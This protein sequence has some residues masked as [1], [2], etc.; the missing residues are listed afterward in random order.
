MRCRENIINIIIV[1]TGAISCLLSVLFINNFI[2]STIF[3]YIFIFTFL[4]IS[5]CYVSSKIFS[6]ITLILFL[7]IYGSKAYS[8]IFYLLYLLIVYLSILFNKKFLSKIKF[9]DKKI[10]YVIFSMLIFKLFDLFYTILVNSYANLYSVL[11]VSGIISADIFYLLLIFLVVIFLVSLFNNFHR[12]NCFLVIVLFIILIANVFKVM[13][14]G[15]PLTINDMI[16]SFTGSK[17]G[18]FLDS[19][20]ISFF[21]EKIV[22]FGMIVVIVGLILNISYKKFNKKFFESKK[23]RFVILMIAFFCLMVLVIPNKFFYNVILNGVFKTNVNKEYDAIVFVK[24]SYEKFGLTLGTYKNYI[25]SLRFEPDDYDVLEVEN[26]LNKKYQLGDKSLKKPN[27][28]MVFSESFW[29]VTKVDGIKFDKDV[30]PNFNS[31]KNKGKV[32]DL[33]TPTL[34]GYSANVEFEVLTGNS[35]NYLSLGTIPYINIYSTKNGYKYPSVI[36]ELKNNGYKTN[37]ISAAS[38]SLFSTESVYKNMGVDH[39]RFLNDEG[40]NYISDKELVDILIDDFSKKEDKPYF[41]TLVTMEGHMPYD[42]VVKNKK[43]S[44]IESKY[45]EK[46]NVSLENFANKIHRA[47]QELKRLNEFINNLEEETIL[48]Y[49]G[50]HLPYFVN[51]GANNIYDDSNYFNGKNERLNLYHLYNTEALI[52]NN[53][54]AVFDDTNYLSNDMLMPYLMHN[55]DL[56]LSNYYHYLYSIKDKV[57]ASNPYITKLNGKIKYTSEVKND[58]FLEREN[59]QYYMLK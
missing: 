30:I 3:T 7:V 13:Y 15:I 57:G 2:L 22:F 17:V 19:N 23:K 54:G 58:I 29:D 28:I 46:T 14:T 45:G 37:I 52:L 55:M 59:V 6:V 50:D 44:L 21:L 5:R 36:K 32:I 38:G 56:E 27:I 31:L 4:S 51:I 8:F 24:L 40:G 53:Y 39:Y 1:I 43:V 12:V 49:F 9:K 16:M 26:I 11:G 48:I 33:V 41:Y 42:N 47:D 34:G 35:M 18:D 10:F 25:E 20:I